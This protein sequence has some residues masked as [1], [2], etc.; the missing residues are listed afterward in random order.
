MYVQ[1]VRT[2]LS[3]CGNLGLEFYAVIRISFQKYSRN[4]F[5]D[6]MLEVFLRY[7][8]RLVLLKSRSRVDDTTMTGFV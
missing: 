1:V 4:N 5:Q 7:V 2:T 6:E 3:T 8:N